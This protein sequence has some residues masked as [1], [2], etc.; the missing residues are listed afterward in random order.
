MTSFSLSDRV[1]LSII[2]FWSAFVTFHSES[3]VQFQLLNKGTQPPHLKPRPFIHRNMSSKSH[4]T[5]LQAA[6]ERLEAAKKQAGS[7]PGL[8]E[9]AAKTVGFAQL[10]ATQLDEGLS[11]MLIDSTTNWMELTRSQVCSAP[12]KK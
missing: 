3:A 5:Q 4:S 12:K 2:K 10:A 9:A 11:K 8:L 6:R 7:A 1:T